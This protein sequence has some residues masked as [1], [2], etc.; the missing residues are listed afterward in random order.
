MPTLF[1][2]HGAGP[3]F[4]MDWNPPDRLGHMARLPENVAAACPRGPTAILLVSGHWVEPAFSVT[5]GPHRS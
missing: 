1:I 3:C 5:S 4:F 2:P